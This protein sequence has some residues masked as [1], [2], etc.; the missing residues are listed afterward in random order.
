MTGSYNIDIYIYIVLGLYCLLGTHLYSFFTPKSHGGIPS[1]DSSPSASQSVSAAEP[2]HSDK[3][4][5]LPDWTSFLPSFYLSLSVSLSLSRLDVT[6]YPKSG[7]NWTLWRP[8]DGGASRSRR[9]AAVGGCLCPTQT[10]E[11]PGGRQLND[12]SG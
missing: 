9:W 10:V 2:N 4:T 7:A 8:C 12:T 11:G 1:R 6:P 3:A 5:E